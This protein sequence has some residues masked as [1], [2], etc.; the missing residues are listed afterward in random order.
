MPLTDLDRL[1]LCSFLWAFE[2][3]PGCEEFENAEVAY[4]QHGLL[5]KDNTLNSLDPASLAR[6]LSTQELAP[7]PRRGDFG[8]GARGARFARF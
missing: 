2:R 6:W 1:F 8:C 5:C 7:A 3:I 4:Q